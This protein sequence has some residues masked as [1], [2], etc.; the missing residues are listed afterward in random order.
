MRGAKGCVGVDVCFFS[1]RLYSGDVYHS[2]GMK[3]RQVGRVCAGIG[4]GDGS[5]GGDGNI[6]GGEGE[7]RKRVK[8][9]AHFSA[10]FIFHD[11]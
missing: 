4:V 5:S 1:R 7:V 6:K 9:L 10:E 2:T 3:I 11:L 8:Y